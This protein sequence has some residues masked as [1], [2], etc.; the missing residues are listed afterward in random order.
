MS[1][2]SL[3]VRNALTLKPNAVPTSPENGDVYY[4]STANLF[5]FYQ[6]G[7]WTGLSGTGGGLSGETAISSGV[8][9]VTVSLGTTLGSSN[10]YINAQ[11]VNTTDANPQFQPVTITA[12]T[13][14]TFTAKW[15]D[16]TDSANYLLDWVIPNASV[17][18]VI[19][20]MTTTGDLIVGGTS[21]TP[22]RLGIGS[23]NT[24]LTSNGTTASWVAPST[25][26]NINMHANSASGTLNGTAT[27]VYGTVDWDTNSAYNV[28][29]GKFT[30]PQA[31]KYRVTASIFVT[32]ASFAANNYI[33]MNIIKNT[34][35]VSQRT[36]YC[37][38]GV[39]GG[40]GYHLQLT[41]TVSAALN[42][43]L[44]IRGQSNATTPLSNSLS[45]VSVLSI[46][47][48]GT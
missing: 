31:G 34:T 10:Y 35:A 1:L 33:I 13:T 23:N 37:E 6:N 21:G 18:G 46:E 44:W 14:T 43:T 11:L 5:Y 4:D 39:S 42:D 41:D 40:N 32:A 47:L 8:A 22:T 20:P 7:A 48:I 38:G 2:N 12:R 24:V 15:N 36:V 28:S 27:Q 29:T 25:L 3:K 26:P 9:T 16:P 19:S 17:V 45:T 30:A